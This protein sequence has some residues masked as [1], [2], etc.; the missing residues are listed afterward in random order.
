MVVQF[1]QACE[2]YIRQCRRR[3]GPDGYDFVAIL[4]ACSV[5]RA[6]VLGRLVVSHVFEVGL[7]H[8]IHVQNTL[9][10]LYAKCGCLE[11]A[12]YTFNHMPQ[13]D[14]VSWNVLMGGYSQVQPHAAL[15]V[16]GRM[17]SEG[18]NPDKYTSVCILKVCA[19]ITHLAQGKLLHFFVVLSSLECDVFVGSALIDMYA[20]CATMVDARSVFECLPERNLVTWNALISGYASHADEKAVFWIFA[21][22]L[23]QEVVPN[24]VSFVSVLKV[25]SSLNLVTRGAHCHSYIIEMAF[26]SNAFLSSI[27]I[28]MYSQCGNL[29]DSFYVF[30]RSMKEDMII[31]SALIT[32]FVRHGHDHESLSLYKYMQQSVLQINAVTHVCILKACS[33]LGAREQGKMIHVHMMENGLVSDTNV[34]N[35]LIDMLVKCD[36]LKD[37]RVVF[38]ELLKRDVVTWNTLIAGYAEHCSDEAFKLFHCMQEQDEDPDTVTII[39]VLKA[40]ARLCNLA[41]GKSIHDYL[42]QTGFPCNVPVINALIDMYNKCGSLTE[43]RKLFNEMPRRDAVTWSAMIAGFVQRWRGEEAFI[44]FQQMLQEGISPNEG[45]LVGVLSACAIE[46]A[47]LAGKLVHAFAVDLDFHSRLAVGNSLIDMYSNSGSYNDACGVFEKMQTRNETT[48]TSMISCFGRYEKYELAFQYYADMLKEGLR[49]NDVT[50]IC[51]LSACS[52]IGR[53]VEGCDL[54]SSLAVHKITPTSQHINCVVDLMGRTNQIQKAEE[55]LV[56]MP[57]HLNAIGWSCLLGHCKTHSN[58]DI[59][60]RCFDKVVT[61]DPEDMSAYSLMISIYADAGL[62]DDINFLEQKKGSKS[63]IIK[64]G[65]GS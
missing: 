8:N 4:R 64:L 30:S 55:L 29:D 32:A 42:R 13:R 28:D 41:E 60:R 48:W 45:A 56:S 51:L 18:S 2:S 19:S 38:D 39:S 52:R 20:S 34:A 58:V 44:Y 57:F 49:P 5:S 17:L 33:N 23:G 12:L 14:V 40:C 6:L 7:S 63:P 53:M 16:W 50:F 47:L 35:A 15:Q 54:F 25:C 37:A 46:T 59:G 36:C 21:C 26:E 62:Y 24:E 31:W 65:E 1:A 9:I 27:L 22:M 3:K 11:D 10:D 43:A 61:L